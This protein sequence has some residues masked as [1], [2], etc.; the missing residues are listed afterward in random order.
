VS[1]HAE[2][3]RAA[4]NDPALATQLKSD[5]R[6]AGLPEKD[7]RMLEFAEQLT[8]HPWIVGESDIH[9]LRQS[10]FHN[11]EMLHIV[12]GSAL[13]N[14]LN[15]MADGIGIQ[16]EYQSS[17]PEFRPKIIETWDSLPKE[18]HKT[19]ALERKSPIAWIRCPDQSGPSSP[20][21]EPVNL[22]RVISEN[23]EASILAKGWRSYHLMPTQ[24]LNVQTRG[25]LALYVSGINDCDYST[26]WF[27][28]FLME[29]ETDRSTLD[30]LSQGKPP[31]GLGK[32]EKL[33]FEHARRMTLEPWT[34]REAQIEELRKMGMDDLG[35]LQLTMLISY[36]SFE[37]RV[38]L[39]LGVAT[40]KALS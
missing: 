3:L 9:I 22:F 36:L 33:Q 10:G 28:R 27:R 16:F 12:L 11:G 8:R 1:A 21:S 25:R 39:G 29:L 37:T 4:T 2:F 20:G 31:A 40:E 13:F 7:F 35:I 19:P 17:L 14:Y 23:S 24:A 38:V 5:F 15:R 34:I 18:R 6:N 30:S 32:L 26:F